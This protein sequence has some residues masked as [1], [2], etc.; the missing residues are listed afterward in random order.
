M[1]KYDPN[2]PMGNYNY[3]I[4]MLQIGEMESACEYLNKSDSYGYEKAPEVLAAYCS[5]YGD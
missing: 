5:G 3:G 1:L 4:L 2:F